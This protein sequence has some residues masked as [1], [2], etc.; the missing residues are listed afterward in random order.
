MK[1]R[2]DRDVAEEAARQA[3]GA[4]ELL[5]RLEFPASQIATRAGIPLGGE[6]RG[7]M[8]DRMLES[9]VT[10]RMMVKV[11]TGMGLE[12]LTFDITCGPV[13]SVTLFAEAVR[14]RS[15][16]IAAGAFEEAALLDAYRSC[17]AFGGR[18]EIVRL[19][20][21]KGFQIPA[22]WPLLADPTLVEPA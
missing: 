15:A 14:R 1:G 8:A 10:L 17:A 13:A 19:L 21:A 7:D 9:A 16:A 22:N 3:W 5:L 20:H 12:S 6:H 18:D 4:R 11:G 2:I